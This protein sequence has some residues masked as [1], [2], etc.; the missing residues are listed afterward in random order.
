MEDVKERKQRQWDLASSFIGFRLPDLGS[1]R[2]HCLNKASTIGMF[3]KGGFELA[4]RLLNC[5]VLFIFVG[6]LLVVGERWTQE[7]PAGFVPPFEPVGK[8]HWIL[9]GAEILLLWPNVVHCKR[10]D[11]H[12]FAVAAQKL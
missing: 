10:F 3:T 11:R 9:A 12:N 5:S 7:E 2:Q 8:S 6:L 1:R 4:T